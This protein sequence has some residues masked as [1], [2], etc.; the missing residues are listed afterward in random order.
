MKRLSNIS[1]IAEQV[2]YFNILNIS[3]IYLLAIQSIDIGK[4]V[5]N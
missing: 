4:Y 3:W 2:L 5:R 1:M